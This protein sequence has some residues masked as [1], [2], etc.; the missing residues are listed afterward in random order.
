ITSIDCDSTPR[1][2]QLST[3]LDEYTEITSIDCDSTPRT[4]QLSTFLDEY[5]GDIEWIVNIPP[6]VNLK[7][8]EYLFPE[9]LDYVM[10]E[11]N[12]GT[13]NATVKTN[14]PLDVDSIESEIENA[15]DLQLEDVNDNSPEFLQALYNT[16]VS[17]VSAINSTVI[18]VEAKDKDLS[19]LFSYISYSLWGPDSDYFYIREGDG[20]IMVNKTLDY[21][22]INHFNLTVQA[23]ER[24][25]NNRDTVS[26]IID[27]QD[28]DTMNPYF[29]Q[30]VYNGTI[31]ENEI[32]PLA[33]LPEKIFARDG[34]TGIN[35][36]VFYSIKLG[37]SF[38]FLLEIQAV[39]YEICSSEENDDEVHE[40]SS[41]QPVSYTHLDV[42]KRQTPHCWI[43]SKYH[44]YIYRACILKK[45]VFFTA[46]FF[47]VTARDHLSPYDEAQSAI[48]ILL[49]DENDNSPTFTGTKY[50]QVIF[51]N[52]TA[53]MSILQVLQKY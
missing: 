31:N 17:E 40:T 44:L 24:F 15:R 50:E 42:Y 1:T 8:K 3:F 35:E 32:G 16:S 38:Y 5:T 18:K 21:N 26:L 53:G 9:H 52:M 29:S 7:L 41:L 45:T 30:P 46:S 37:K 6:N 20:N 12:S 19:P 34:D 36:K 47:K 2:L 10:L 4:L 43:G 25:G 23:K 39:T 51:I 33:I 48:N 11:Y 27:V 13:N 28:Y 49:L 22:K 14:K